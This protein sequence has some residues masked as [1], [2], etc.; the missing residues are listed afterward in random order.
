MK[1]SR[2]FIYIRAMTWTQHKTQT[3]LHGFVHNYNK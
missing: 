1:Y 3:Q 2:L